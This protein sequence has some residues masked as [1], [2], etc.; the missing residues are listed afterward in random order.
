VWVVAQPSHASTYHG[1]VRTAV[2]TPS[3][4]SFTRLVAGAGAQLLARG[5]AGVDVALPAQALRSELTRLKASPSASAE[6]VFDYTA[7]AA[8]TAFALPLGYS[9]VRVASA[10]LARREGAAADW[11]RS[12]DGWVETISFAVAP[13]AGTWV[14]ITARRQP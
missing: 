7:A 2:A 10:G 5:A 4:G 8:Q 6:E 12:F 1:L 13:G 14:Q 11:Q 9:A 3:A